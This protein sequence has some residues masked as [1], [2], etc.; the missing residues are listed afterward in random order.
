LAAL[1][2]L[3]FFPQVHLP[4]VQVGCPSVVTS[5]VQVFQVLEHLVFDADKNNKRTP[6]ESGTTTLA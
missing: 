5:G 4:L 2:G 1:Q 3:H 6:H